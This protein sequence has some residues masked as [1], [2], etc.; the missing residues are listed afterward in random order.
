MHE[1]T[2]G[3]VNYLAVRLMRGETL[4]MLD[5][6]GRHWVAR[7]DRL[8]LLAS[9]RAETTAVIVGDAYDVADR[10]AGLVP[11]FY[12]GRPARSRPAAVG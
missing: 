12:P 5:E 11:M 2:H 8:L 6:H 4:E 3:I 7:Y 1:I 10:F 9:E